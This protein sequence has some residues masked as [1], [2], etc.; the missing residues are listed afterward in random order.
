MAH[1]VMTIVMIVVLPSSTI[2]G[3]YNPDYWV[4]GSLTKYAEATYGNASYTH[5][6]V[7]SNGN[8]VVLN[9]GNVR[10]YDSELTQ[11]SSKGI[12][13]SAVAVAPL[14][15]GNFVVLSKGGTTSPSYAKFRIYDSL[16]NVALDGSGN[17]YPIVTV[18][19]SHNIAY[20]QPPVIA[21][22]E[23]GHFVIAY[24]VD[25]GAMKAS[26]FDIDGTQLQS[27]SI[28]GIGLP[29]YK[30]ALVSTDTGWL[31]ASG[32][33]EV[34]SVYISADLSSSGTVQEILAY[35]NG[36]QV[37]SLELIRSDNKIKAFIVFQKYYYTDAKH[38]IVNFHHDGSIAN[39]A[40]LIRTDT[41]SDDAWKR[42]TAVAVH[43]NLFVHVYSERASG[44]PSTYVIQQLDGNNNTIGTP[45]SFT[46]SATLNGDLHSA[47][48]NH[49]KFVFIEGRNKKVHLMSTGLDPKDSDSDGTPDIEDVFPTDALLQETPSYSEILPITDGLTL[50]LDASA[51]HGDT[52][53]ISDENYLS[54]WVDFSG[55]GNHVTQVDNARKPVFDT[56]IQNGKSMIRFDGSNDYLH[57]EQQTDLDPTTFTFFTIT[58][59]LSESKV[60]FVG[61]RGTTGD[62]GYWLGTESSNRFTASV[63]DGGSA[64]ARSSI[65]SVGVS[66][67]KLF[68]GKFDGTTNTL[69][70][71]GLN[72]VDTS[73]SGAM[74]YMSATNFNIGNIGTDHTD[75]SSEQYLNGH[76][77]EVIL[78]NR[79]LSDSEMMDIH[80]YLSTKWGL[81]SDVDSDGDGLVDAYDAAPKDNTLLEY[82]V[83]ELTW[84]NPGGKNV[85]LKKGT[86]NLAGTSG[87]TGTLTL[88]SNLGDSAVLNLSG[89]LIADTIES[90][91]GSFTLNLSGSPVLKV[92]EINAPLNLDVIRISPKSGENEIVF[93]SDVTLGGSVR[94]DLSI[95]DTSTYQTLKLNSNVTFSGEFY[96]NFPP[97]YVVSTSDSF[98]VIDASGGGSLSGSYRFG[99]LPDAPQ[100]YMWD[101]SKLAITGK[102][103]IK[104][105]PAYWDM[106]SLLAPIGEAFVVNG[107]TTDFQKYPRAVQLE[108]GNI[109]VCYVDYY[110]NTFSKLYFKIIQP[111]GTAVLSDVLIASLSNTGVEPFGVHLLDGGNI[112]LVWQEQGNQVYA[113]VM[114]QD[115]NVIKSRFS[116]FSNSVTPEATSFSTH[117]G[118]FAFAYRFYDSKQ[119]TIKKYSNTGVLDI[120]TNFSVSN[121]SKGAFDIAKAGTDRY[122]LVY[123]NSGYSKL[124][125]RSLSS[126]F[127]K[128][129]DDVEIRATST[130]GVYFPHLAPLENGT[131]AVM[132]REGNYPLTEYT[133]YISILSDK[134]DVI[135]DAQAV[136]SSISTVYQVYGS[137]VSEYLVFAYEGVGGIANQD[138]DIYSV[139]I[140]VMAYSVGWVDRSVIPLS[141][142]QFLFIG[143]SYADHNLDGSSVAIIARRYQLSEP[144]LDRDGDGTAD[145]DD[146]F[147][148]DPNLQEIPVRSIDIPVTTGL[149]LWLD[150]SLP[151]GTNYSFA[152]ETVMGLWYDFSGKANHVSQTVSDYKPVLDEAVLN[153]KSMIRFDGIN[154]YFHA[155]SQTDLAPS[156]L[157]F[158][159]ITQG[160]LTTKAQFIAGRGNTSEDGYWFGGEGENTFAFSTGDGDFGTA[161]R[162]KFTNPGIEDARLFSGRIDGSTNQLYKMGLGTMASTAT[163]TLV[164]TGSP[165]FNVGNIGAD[166]T[167]MSSETFLNGHVGEIVMYNRALSDT[168]MIAVHYY[169]S[170]KWGL[171]SEVDSDG[172]GL[173]DVYDAS[174]TDASLIDYDVDTI[175]W[176][177]PNGRDVS[178]KNGVVSLLGDSGAVDTLILGSESGYTSE[179]QLTGTLDVDTFTKGPGSSTLTLISNPTLVLKTVSDAMVLGAA[180][181]K[182]KDGLVTFLSDLTVGS[183]SK[184]NL[185]ITS[186][187]VYDTVKVNGNLTLSGTLDLT[188]LSSY[189]PQEGD[190]LTLFDLSGGSGSISG[191]FTS[192]VGL[193][194]TRKYYMWDLSN[195]YTEGKI[196]LIKDMT[197]WVPGGAGEDHGDEFVISTTVSSLGLSRSAMLTNGNIAH[198]YTEWEGSGWVLKFTIID[199]EGNLIVS[200]TTVASDVWG[201][202]RARDSIHLESGKFAFL[203]SCNSDPETFITIYNNDGTVALPKTKVS[204]YGG[205]RL[206]LEVNNSGQ[207]ISAIEGHIAADPHKISVM[208]ED[209]TFDVYDMTIPGEPD[210]YGYPI[211]LALDDG[212][213]Y[214]IG[215]DYGAYDKM[216]VQKF[217][218][219]F[220]QIGSTQYVFNALSSGIYN[221][222][223]AARLS[224]GKVVVSAAAGDYGLSLAILDQDLNV[225]HSI[226]NVSG[227]GPALDNTTYVAAIEDGKF[228][229]AYEE[230]SSAGATGYTKYRIYDSD[231]NLIKS[232]TAV[233]SG[234]GIN[235]INELRTASDGTVLISYKPGGTSYGRLFEGELLLDRDADGVADVNDEFPDD[236]SISVLPSH[237]VLPPVTSGLEMWLDGKYP[238]GS[239]VNLSHGSAATYWIDFSGKGRHFSQFNT[240]KKPTLKASNIGAQQSMNFSSSSMATSS[241]YPL[242]SQYTVFMAYNTVGFGSDFEDRERVLLSR[243]QNDGFRLSYEDERYLRV[244]LSQDSSGGFQKDIQ[245]DS[246]YGSHYFVGLNSNGS[247]LDIVVNGDQEHSEAVSTITYPSG[248]TLN[249]GSST[250]ASGGDDSATYFSGGIG[251]VLIYNRSLSETEMMQISNFLATRWELDGVVDSDHDTLVDFYDGSP[252]NS[253]VLEYNVGTTFAWLPVDN[254]KDVYLMAGNVQVTGEAGAVNVVKL[255]SQSGYSSR[256]DIAGTVTI[257]AL[258]EGSGI[259]ALNMLGGT[260]KLKEATLDLTFS[261]GTLTPHDTETNMNINGNLTLLSS[262]IVALDYGDE[263]NITGTTALS[264]TLALNLPDTLELV[265]DLE[266]NILNSTGAI[267]GEFDTIT[268]LPEAEK[269]YRWETHHITANGTIKYMRDPKHWIYSE[270]Q[271]VVS[272]SGVSSN[273]YPGSA[274]LSNGNALAVY[275]KTDKQIYIQVFAPDGTPVV[276]EMRVDSVTYSDSFG[277][278]A[279]R[280]SDGRFAVVY[281]AQQSGNWYLKFKIFNNDGTA[282]TSTIQV[283]SASASM[284]VEMYPARTSDNGFSVHYARSDG[285]YVARYDNDGNVVVAPKKTV[286]PSNKYY[287]VVVPMTNGTSYLIYYNSLNVW[288]QRLDSNY[289]TLGSSHLISNSEG[290]LAV[291]RKA[292]E[293]GA[294]KVL[295]PYQRQVSGGLYKIQARIVNS[296]GSLFTPQTTVSQ[297]TQS[298]SSPSTGQYFDG[299]YILMYTYS[300]GAF[301]RLMNA[302]GSL[303]DEFTWPVKQHDPVTD[304]YDGTF[305]SVGL[306]G[307]MYV[308]IESRKWH[309][310]RDADGTVDT[311]DE[312]PDDPNFQTTPAHDTLPPVTDGL[313]LWLD[314]KAPNS[315][316]ASLSSGD[317]LTYWMD[318][319]GNGRHFTQVNSAKQPQYTASKIASQP[320]V[321]FVQDTMASPIGVA[322]TNQ[323]SV[324]M[325]YD[326]T[327]FGDD[328]EAGSRVLLS[329]GENNGFRVSYK[330][331]Q[332]LR[333]QLSHTSSGGYQT[334]IQLDTFYGGHYFLGLNSDGSELDIHV[335][336][337]QRHSSAASPILY[338]TGI[339]MNIG[340]ATTDSGGSDTGTNFIGGIGD[341]LVYDRSLTSTEMREISYFLSSRWDLDDVVDSD[342]DGLF[343]F[344]DGQPTD[345]S[346]LEYNVGTSFAWLPVDN[347]K[348]VYLMAGNV[349]LTG[350]GG[351]VNTLRLGSRAGYSSRLDLFGTVTVNV[352]EEGDGAG[353]LNVASGTLKL[354]ASN[355]SFLHSNGVLKPHDTQTQITINGDY[356][357]LNTATLS[358]DQGETLVVNGD[359]VL[360][361]KLEINSDEGLTLEDELTITV[362]DV[363]GTTAGQFSSI[364]GLPEPEMY[365]RWETH[366]ITANGTIK[367]MRDP[368]YWIFTP[369]SNTNTALD[370]GGWPAASILKNGNIALSYFPRGGTPARLKGRIFNS[371]GEEIVSEFEIDST[372]LYSAYDV[373]SQSLS[374]GGYVV[375]FSSWVNDKFVLQFKVFNANGTPRTALITIAESVHNSSV[376]QVRATPRGGFSVSWYSAAVSERYVA[377]YSGDDGSA[378]QEPK[379]V[380]S[381]SMNNIVSVPLSG[382]GTHVLL[383]SADEPNHITLRRYDENYTQVGSSVRVDTYSSTAQYPLGIESDSN[384]YLSVFSLLL[385]SSYPVKGRFI[386]EDTTM[387]TEFLIS[388]GSAYYTLLAV[389]K[390]F[391]DKM[392]VFYTSSGTLYRQLIYKNGTLDGTQ[393]TLG[394]LSSG[395]NLSADFSGNTF[396]L[397]TEDSYGDGKIHLLIE[398][399]GGWELDRDSDGVADISDEFPDD[400]LLQIMPTY[401]DDIPSKESL[402]VW[403]DGSQPHGDATSFSV[404]DNLKTWVD[405]SGNGHHATQVTGSYQPTIGTFPNTSKTSLVFDGSN[406]RMPLNLALTGQ[407]VENMIAF[408]VYK[409]SS[410]GNYSLLSFDADTFFDISTSSSGGY[411]LSFQTAGTGMTPLEGELIQGI[412]AAGE[413]YVYSA[414]F[415]KEKHGS[416]LRKVLRENGRTLGVNDSVDVSLGVLGETR[417]GYIGAPSEATTFAGTVGSGGFASGSIA[418]IIIYNRFMNKSEIQ[419]IETYLARKWNLDKDLALDTDAFPFA[420]SLGTVP[421]H[422]HTASVTDGLVLYF[423]SEYALGD[424]TSLS[425][426]DRLPAW[427]NL[428]DGEYHAVQPNITNQP[429]YKE[430]IFGSRPGIQFTGNTFMELP[431]SSLSDTNTSEFTLIFEIKQDDV[432]TNYR[433]PY[434]SRYIEPDGTTLGQSVYQNDTSY[435]SGWLAVPGT[436]WGKANSTRL[437]K[438]NKTTL[439]TIS[440]DGTTLT[441]REDGLIL[442]QKNMTYEVNNHVSPRLGAGGTEKLIPAYYFIGYLGKVL[443]YSKS[444][445]ESELDM[446]EDDIKQNIPSTSQVWVDKNFTG[447]SYGSE[448]EPFTSFDDAL[449]VV[450]TG[451]E[452]I[453]KNSNFP[454]T[455]TITKPVTI[456]S[457]AGASKLGS[458]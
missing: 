260:L 417:Y 34:K 169:L 419:D 346:I 79:A 426:G 331:E 420:A 249:I 253:S 43:D 83:T 382:G 362:L 277:P 76:L 283:G 197:Y 212:N 312:F 210:S 314:G 48:L 291:T 216:M 126:D 443:L 88:G 264:G 117:D 16:G 159:T 60:Q 166:H 447:S 363:S 246:F 229:V 306:Y 434:T 179:L 324:F 297:S 205:G 285:I 278:R 290:Y 66:Q 236:P 455:K 431:L 321:E 72:S 235:N 360:G 14:P 134:G 266:I 195:L 7:L 70:H 71:M 144:R 414:A 86:V 112:A 401:Q 410:A 59:G 177:Q 19:T 451:G 385:S 145:E 225:E 5:T 170:T 263:I 174:P 201:D 371:Q 37:E 282:H 269:Y 279:V 157:T 9:G 413:A 449:E 114:D 136:E 457:S 10:V 317:N 35:D 372:D 17:S 298:Y 33:Y 183:S 64:S 124:F 458:D 436:T 305:V 77:G 400:P 215:V 239:S 61:G 219:T 366:H 359:A 452:I 347:S 108:N 393:H 348:D 319:S 173:V 51:P 203:Y 378:I 160:Q 115:G 406:D 135:R 40:Q 350:E 171:S 326:T 395:S 132:F 29:A 296:D 98:T 437:V 332:Y 222:P 188:V 336:G 187:S 149:T 220:T 408:I 103:S 65:G 107:I 377:E 54:S 322:I 206:H 227:V 90:G 329:R 52:S 238:Y 237:S 415:R 240:S 333:F 454:F 303:E 221:Y 418:E 191:E 12:I 56:N 369:A 22:N 425:D 194:N 433:S 325:A 355:T 189:I 133:G 398:T 213:Y 334:D 313:Q 289:N 190:E 338:P 344:Y 67:P 432:Y 435:W 357:Q 164:Y 94:I 93:N 78:F 208:N 275:E 399:T 106:S 234:S 13:G 412:S 50:W 403:L 85:A 379:L 27:I 49:G 20:M 127:V 224:N 259:G 308:V 337:I 241:G 272:I 307:T 139:D 258:I 167:S 184:I 387:G 143:Q 155:Y 6:C 276:S 110:G 438:E 180:T 104:R 211:T 74:S 365:Y 31:L 396:A 204:T 281:H 361:G 148:D 250:G 3:D 58:K 231:L 89:L 407:S 26:L 368:K 41:G 92:H 96:F 91:A 80:Y 397:A 245:L 55:K 280:L 82:D 152:D 364:E 445:T 23:S 392:A 284:T 153:G 73:S 446:I 254:T 102:I 217:S 30:H 424:E 343:D 42:A 388:Q 353:V 352:Y 442:H 2:L 448:A 230:A 185:T 370:V 196:T 311:E 209:G 404:G 439:L 25:G 44:G 141:D 248:V 376:R 181:L 429:I 299:K 349:Q 218:P 391:D 162:S 81:G 421:V 310:D 268:G 11:I 113:Q 287:Q 247:V 18:N 105:D 118:G 28:S 323:Y 200:P 147:P 316:G 330:D 242:A 411:K 456:K 116:V 202:Y 1:C 182:P 163:N 165:E 340:A 309:L 186:N 389:S 293:F 327:A 416:S 63:G 386:N 318:F 53:G 402:L 271:N 427:I 422:T 151:L 121:K 176:V 301:A 374:N 274:V 199:R 450:K 142:N 300:R 101:T 161:P 423:D 270:D 140:D 8:V 288:G 47:L 302:D 122:I 123:P 125:A 390:Y 267:S 45:Y 265:H 262:A 375:V 228:I 175:N 342:F 286:N 62:Y 354:L 137:G 99:G 335:N 394:G 38:Y 128:L 320:A 84:V 341:I 345:D 380:Y 109:A 232:E 383:A 119:Y 367:Y 244:Q 192:I 68:V 138:G 15:N 158:F 46:S 32:Q 261:N 214:V 129:E 69:Y 4:S 339:T 223:R 428:A 444:L 294:N 146:G 257:N 304:Y 315:S 373:K 156:T 193:E 87:D 384:Q 243:G 130:N 207:I 358:L 295:V 21:V 255:G 409:T 57:V 381:G 150:G 39:S 36:L 154:D 178:L 273:T 75:M 95:T 198:S 111:D 168:E 351:A 441:L 131:V 328:F 251:D 120:N 24:Y 405:L 356:T 226:S 100:Y 256:L 97:G 453:I 292:V 172:D 440:Y 430:A 252:V 233:Y